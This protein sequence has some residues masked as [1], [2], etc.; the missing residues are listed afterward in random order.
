MRTSPPQ[1]GWIRKFGDAFRGLR[2]GV[3]GQS[4]F[5]VHAVVATAVVA[6]GWFLEVSRIEWCLLVLSISLV[7]AIEMINSALESLAPAIRDEHDPRIGAVLDIASGA[8]LL[9]SI[10]AAVVGII[11]LG[12]RAGLWLGWIG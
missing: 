11:I 6:C 12:Y 4:S 5:A 7:L 8:V 9:A 3:A 1:R 2:L 10:G